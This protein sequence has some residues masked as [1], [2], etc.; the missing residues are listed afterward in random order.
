MYRYLLIIAA[1]VL[2]AQIILAQDSQNQTLTD[3][4]KLIE[5][6]KLVEAQ[7]LLEIQKLMEAQKLVDAQ[8]NSEAMKFADRG[9]NYK[10]FQLAEQLNLDVNNYLIYRA[11]KS[12]RIKGGILMGIGGGFL[13]TGL[14]YFICGALI[15]EADSYDDDYY[16]YGYDE[17]DD[18]D[19][20]ICFIVGGVCS[21]IGAGLMVGG[22]AVRSKVRE[23]IRKDGNRLSL[24]PKIDLLNDCFGAELS[25]SF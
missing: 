8:K 7:K 15:D 10:H 24:M 16:Y 23:V 20:A 25:L 1:F 18:T 22:G 12:H 14:L 9:L 21:T 17:A 5:A 4:Q 11:N 13:G 3:E 19:R 6:Q 2:Q